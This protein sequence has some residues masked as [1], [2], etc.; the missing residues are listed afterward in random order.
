MPILDDINEVNEPSFPYNSLRVSTFDDLENENR[1]YS[2]NLS[3]EERLRY[4]HELNI[5]A[6]R[7]D[8]LLMKGFG[9]IIIFNP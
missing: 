5:N 2:F 4:L 8:S 3:Y 7:K 1:M 6:F 9:S